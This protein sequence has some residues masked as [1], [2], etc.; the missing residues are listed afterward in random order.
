MLKRLD[1]VYK[2]YL[3]GLIAADGHLDAKE[4]VIVIAQKDKEFIDIIAKI[5]EKIGVSVSSVFYDKSARVW[6]LKI[7]DKKFYNYLIENGVVEGRKSDK[8][9]PPKTGLKTKEAL[10]YVIGFIDGDGWI[11]QV[12]KKRKGKIYHYMRIGIKTKSENICN[13][14]IKVLEANGIKARKANKKNSYEIQIDTLLAWK[15]AAFLLNPKHKNK[16]MNIRDDR[17][18]RS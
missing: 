1:K 15:L 11:E 3:C 6:K 10:A 9:N 18:L 2:M 17:T 7:R 13:W 5:L 16:L 4:K 12:K 8:I 14:M